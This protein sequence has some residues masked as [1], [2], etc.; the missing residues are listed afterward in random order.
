M[1]EREPTRLLFRLTSVPPQ[2]LCRLCGK[3]GLVHT[4][5]ANC[6]S[7]RANHSGLPTASR[8]YF[9]PTSR[10]MRRKAF[11][12]NLS[13]LYSM[14]VLKWLAQN[15][16]SLKFHHH[17]RIE[18]TAAFGGITALIRQNPR[19]TELVVYVVMSMPME[20]QRNAASRNKFIEV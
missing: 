11:S 16:A 14:E 1:E 5:L 6:P 12:R 4:L 15:S 17:P 2:V 18:A 8:V 19:R 7:V 3:P 9:W 13:F 10:N 20:P